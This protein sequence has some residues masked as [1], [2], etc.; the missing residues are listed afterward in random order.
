MLFSFPKHHIGEARDLVF[1]FIIE[2][3]RPFFC[4]FYT[5]ISGGPFL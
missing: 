2:K 5:G 3:K 1:L 4:D